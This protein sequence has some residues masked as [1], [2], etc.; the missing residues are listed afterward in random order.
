MSDE[1][2][3]RPTLFTAEGGE[4]LPLDSANGTDLVQSDRRRIRRRLGISSAAVALALIVALIV[5]GAGGPGSKDASAQVMLGARTTLAK[6]SVALTFSGSITVNGQSIPISGTG[7][8]DLSTHV[9]SSTLSF[10]IPGES[11]QETVLVNDSTAYMKMIENDQNL[12][13]E[14]LP[15]KQW[16]V[17]VMSSPT[18]NLSSG[19]VLTQLQLLTQQ[20]NHVVS[21]G[22]SSIN[23]KSVTGYQVNVT[24]KAIRD[25]EMRFSTHQGISSAVFSSLEKQPPVIKIWVGANHL[26]VREEVTM[27]LSAIGTTEAGNVVVDFSNYGTPVLI[28]IPPAGIVGSYSQFLAAAKAAG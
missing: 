11:I 7:S 15:G 10:S 14:L 17:L 8:A 22:S 6:N 23:G 24:A 3:T 25:A 27:Q 20:G 12:I 18:G 4:P 2:E 19:N 5:I 21:L 9:E 28:S 16:V 13:S 1:F 26:A